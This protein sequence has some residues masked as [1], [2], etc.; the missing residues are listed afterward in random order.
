MNKIKTLEEFK[1]Q[2]KLTS[3]DKIIE[4]FYKTGLKLVKIENKIEKGIETPFRF[5]NGNFSEYWYEYDYDEYRGALSML[6]E[7]KVI[8]EAKDEQNRNLE[9]Y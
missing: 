7:L 3:K 5:D 8:L 1:K 9:R 6:K 2:L 4:M